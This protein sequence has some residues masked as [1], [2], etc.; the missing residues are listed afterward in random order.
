[1]YKRQNDYHVNKGSEDTDDVNDQVKVAKKAIT[2]MEASLNKAKD[3]IKVGKKG[4]GANDVYQDADVKEAVMI[5][6]SKA[7]VE[8]FDLTKVSDIK[9]VHV[10]D[11]EYTLTFK[12]TLPNAT[13]VTSNTVS[14]SYTHLDVYKR[15]V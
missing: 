9:V 1:M 13:Q 15:Q 6:M 8:N 4:T 3:P 11:N 2:D 10:K 5:A 7:K 14:V 12:Y